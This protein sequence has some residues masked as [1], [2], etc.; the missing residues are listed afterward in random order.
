MK[1]LTNDR[2]ESLRAACHLYCSPLILADRDLYADH[3]F[4][5]LSES[6]KYVDLFNGIVV[7]GFTL[8]VPGNSDQCRIICFWDN[9][10][11]V[12]YFRCLNFVR[13]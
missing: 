5:M 13:S 1:K 3:L 9:S 2:L 8:W 12:S 7:Y 6:L 4:S 10:F 11:R